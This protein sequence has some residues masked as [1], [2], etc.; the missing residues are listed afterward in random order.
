[1]GGGGGIKKLQRAPLEP[2]TFSKI[3]T[4][5]Q[6]YVNSP[7]WS[8]CPFLDSNAFPIK[9]NIKLNKSIKEQEVS[10]I[11]FARYSIEQLMTIGYHQALSLNVSLSNL[12]TSRAD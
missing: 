3:N 11:D 8:G 5:Y 12:M 6:R 7:C 1:M 4:C 10:R 9:Q 2:G